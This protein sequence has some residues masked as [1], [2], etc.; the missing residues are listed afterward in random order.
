M[1]LKYLRT[2]LASLEAIHRVD[3]NLRQQ[4]PVVQ[5]AHR[6]LQFLLLA[7]V[8]SYDADRNRKLIVVDV[9][10]TGD[11]DGLQQLQNELDL[12]FVHKRS[13]HVHLFGR[14]LK[15]EDQVRLECHQRIATSR[16]QRSVQPAVVEHTRWEA[17][18][19]LGITK[20]KCKQIPFMRRNCRHL[21]SACGTDH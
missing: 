6:Q 5:F 9:Q 18:N 11:H 17:N 20:T 4:L 7:T 3:V 16:P 8:E 21:P 15:I 10:V 12:T 13:I 19:V 14:V 2:Q 1:L